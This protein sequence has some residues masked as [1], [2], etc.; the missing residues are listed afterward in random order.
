MARLN[1]TVNGTLA[2]K[3]FVLLDSRPNYYFVVDLSL[4]LVHSSLGYTML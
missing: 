1:A 2:F 4:I 3:I